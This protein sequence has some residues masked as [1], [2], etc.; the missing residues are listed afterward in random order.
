M[1][2]LQANMEKLFNG[3]FSDYDTKGKDLLTIKYKLMNAVN[4]SFW[5]HAKKNY[6]IISWDSPIGED[7]EAVLKALGFIATW[8]GIHGYRGDVTL[9]LPKDKY[10]TCP[11]DIKEWFNTLVRIDNNY[12]RILNLFDIHSQFT[13]K[14]AKY[15]S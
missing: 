5:E 10:K 13:I 7:S 14:G 9:F 12:E 8:D 15:G 4:A 11:K 3:V 1:K 6:W 2:Q